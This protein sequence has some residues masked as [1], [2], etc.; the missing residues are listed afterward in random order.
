VIATGYYALCGIGEHIPEFVF[1]KVGVD[2][3]EEVWSHH[4]IIVRSTK[5]FPAGWKEFVEPA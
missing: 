4:P 3:L 1:G 2:S 5:A